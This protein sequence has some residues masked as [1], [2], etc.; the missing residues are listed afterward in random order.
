[1][2]GIARRTAPSLRCSAQAS[3]E[4]GLRG[5]RITGSGSSVPE[6]V[7][8]NSDLEKLV[9]TND[10]WIATRTGIRRRHVMAAGESLSSHAAAAANRALEMAGVSAADIDVVLLATSTPDDLFGS[11]CQVVHLSNC[12][13]CF[14]RVCIA[15]LPSMH[16][17]CVPRLAHAAMS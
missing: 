14:E 13:S 16:V 3:S 17:D 6:A 8:S 9:E 10:E 11:A 2:H 7:L 12:C 4:H 1:M 5:C 15:G